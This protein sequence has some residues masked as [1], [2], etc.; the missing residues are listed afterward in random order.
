MLPSYIIEAA[1]VNACKF[2]IGENK[3]KLS[4]ILDHTTESTPETRQYQIIQYT[5]MKVITC[6]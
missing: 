4:E 2:E 1:V 5:S 3:M 6:W